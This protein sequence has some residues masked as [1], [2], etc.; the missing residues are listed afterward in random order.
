MQVDGEEAQLCTG[1]YR[2]H[3]SPREFWNRV[4]TYPPESV[5]QRY[6]LESVI[7]RALTA[8]GV[9]VHLETVFNVRKL[10]QRPLETA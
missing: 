7:D 8:K 10:L 2:A 1:R 5:K 4:Y 6:M 3:F 9:S